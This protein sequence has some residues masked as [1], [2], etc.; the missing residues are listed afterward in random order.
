MGLLGSDAV[1]LLSPIHNVFGL[2]KNELNITNTTSINTIFSNIKPDII[3]NCAGY[4]NVD[5]CKKNVS[6]ANEINAYGAYNLANASKKYNSTI[7]HIS[8]DY[9]FDGKKEKPYIELD[10]PNPLNIYGKSKL[11]GEK[12]V[13]QATP[14]HYIIRTS[15]LYGKNGNNFVKTIINASRKS[16]KNELKVVNDQIGSPTYSIDLINAIIFIIKQKSYGTYHV[17]NEGYCSWYDFAKKILQLSNINKEILPMCSEEL[18]RPA[19]R[20]KYSVLDNYKLRKQFNYTLRAWD[21]ALEDY[22]EKEM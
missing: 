7:V 5:N 9:I 2:T 16:T 10:K 11:L 15:W 22:S 4:T 21:K 6:L 20:P 12:L 19:I 8:T 1:R 17:S 13:S 14:K 3:I 18:E